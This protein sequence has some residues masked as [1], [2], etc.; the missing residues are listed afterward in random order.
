MKGQGLAI[1]VDYKGKTRSLDAACSSE[2][3]NT[4]FICYIVSRLQ[5]KPC[6]S[7]FKYAHMQP[8]RGILRVYTCV[9]IPTTASLGTDI[10]FM[11]FHRR[12]TDSC[13]ISMALAILGSEGLAS[14][15]PP[16]SRTPQNR[17]LDPSVRALRCSSDNNS[18]YALLSVYSDRPINPCPLTTP[19]SRAR[20]HASPR[21]GAEHIVLTCNKIRAL[22][23]NSF[24][25]YVIEYFP[26]L[27][28]DIHFG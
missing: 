8:T 9:R 21:R 17:N 25:Y 26:F 14:L 11:H 23:H 20:D 12:D 22:A 27:V 4:Y 3:V 2:R 13:A 5:S 19:K 15:M 28:M 16:K 18:I 7:L 1:W 24:R 6:S 10:G